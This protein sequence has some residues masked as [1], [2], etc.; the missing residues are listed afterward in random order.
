MVTHASK[1]PELTDVVRANFEAAAATP[2][3]LYLF[4]ETNNT[5]GQMFREGTDNLVGDLRDIPTY[6]GS[7]APYIESYVKISANP[8]A[9][10]SSNEAVV[11]RSRHQI[12]YF[13]DTPIQTTTLIHQM[14]IIGSQ[15]AALWALTRFLC[16]C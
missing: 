2:E 8:D 1:S 12:D 7:T 14:H 5:Q 4:S 9:T 6:L 15:L 3:F 13:Q 10:S 11:V 16:L